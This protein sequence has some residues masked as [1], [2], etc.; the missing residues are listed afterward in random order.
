MELKQILEEFEEQ[1]VTREKKYHSFFYQPERLIINTDNA[2]TKT[3]NINETSFNKVNFNLSKPCLNVKSIQLLNINVPLTTAT[4]FNDYELI[5]PY[6]RL[7][8]Q[9]NFDDT[10]TIIEEPSLSNMYF[11]RLLPSYYPKNI[12]PNSQNYGFNKTFNNYQELSD[13]LAKACINDLAKTNSGINPSIPFVSNDIT[14]SYNETENKFQMK[15]N[16]INNRIDTNY[17]PVWVN[18]ETYNKNDIVYNFGFFYI[19]LIDNNNSGPLTET[20]APYIETPETI[21]N[22]YLI[23]GYDDPNVQ[24]MME[25]V[26]INSALFDFNYSVLYGKND[27]VDIPPQPYFKNSTYTLSR[28]LGFNWVGTYTWATQINQFVYTFGDK[29]PLL[30]NRLRPIPPYEFLP[31]ILGSVPIPNNDPYKATT[32]IA[33]GFCNLVLTSMIYLYGNFLGTST[34]SSTNSNNI[35][36]IIPI[37]C[38]SLGISFISEFLDNPLTKVNNTIQDIQLEFRNEHDQPIYFGNNGVITFSFKI[39]Y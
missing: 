29:Q 2:V 39:L 14:I 24:S 7:K 30:Y 19:S 23:A 21:W 33:D 8:T 37:N 38:D 22:T 20:W 32:Y 25:I 35:I 16:N 13:E 4:S 1:N 28:R 34:F 12:I 11:I 9:R 6:Y 31:E 36:G 10:Y 18:D 17:P 5:F 15:G 26:N 3:F 27:I